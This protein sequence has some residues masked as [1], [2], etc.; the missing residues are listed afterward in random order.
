MHES[1]D[2]GRPGRA[3][4]GVA[5]AGWKRRSFESSASEAGDTRGVHATRGC[6][7]GSTGGQ[8]TVLFGL[9]KLR[10]HAVFA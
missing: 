1:F 2:P 6:V 4:A 7:L 9:V 5:K 8:A 3:P 10:P